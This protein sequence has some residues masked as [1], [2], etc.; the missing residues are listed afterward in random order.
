MN[1]VAETARR[2]GCSRSAVRKAIKR[3]SLSAALAEDQWG[4]MVYGVTDDEIERY[5]RDSLGR[6]GPKRAHS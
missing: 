5:R 3:G 1:G 6:R 2:L 4:Q